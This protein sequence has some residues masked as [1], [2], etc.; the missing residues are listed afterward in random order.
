MQT[1]SPPVRDLLLVGGGHTHIQVLRSLGMQPIPGVRVTLLTREIRSPYSG[2]LPGHIAGYYS[3]DDM[4]VDL[5]PL[6]HRAGV[7]LIHGEVTGLDIEARRV[8]VHD[9]PSIAFDWLSLN[10]GALPQAPALGPGGGPARGIAVKPIGRF[11]PAWDQARALLPAGSSVAVV[12]AGA[13][14]VELAFALLAARSD[15]Q[16]SIVGRQW[17]PGFSTRAGQLLQQQAMARGIT[18]VLGVEAKDFIGDQLHLVDGAPLIAHEVFWVTDVVAPQWLKTSQLK[19]DDRGFVVVDETLRSV[20]HPHVL[21]A[22]DV[23]CLYGQERA[24]SGV[25]AVRAGP[26]LT[27]NL[28][29]IPAGT[30]LRR[31]R[32]QQHFLRLLGTSD[33][34]AV[35]A[36]WGI[37]VSGP[38]MWRWKDWIDRE[39]M[40]RFRD[41]PTRMATTASVLPEVM[42]R[43]VPDL[44]R[45]GGCGAKLG[46]DL[47]QRV[48]ARLPIT[49]RAGVLLGIGDDAAEIVADGSVL[50]S[51][52]GL[53]TMVD[54]PYRFGRIVTHHNLNDLYAMGAI[55]T[56]AVALATIP[57]MGEHLMEEEL[58]ALL[59]GVVDVLE[60]HDVPLVGGHSAE[61]AELF[62]GLTVTGRRGP[63]TFTK[64]G[65]KPG[66]QLILT[67]PIGTGVI[68]A[69]AKRGLPVADALAEAMLSM[70]TSN[71]AAVDILVGSGA[72]GVTD[73]TGFGLLGHLSEM[74]RASGVGAHVAVESV[75]I[76]GGA[77]ALLDSGVRS[78]LQA[79]NEQVLADFVVNGEL[80]ARL[81]C[82]PQTSGGLLAGVSK[83]GAQQCVDRLRA[84]GFVHAVVIGEVTTGSCELIRRF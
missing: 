36:K 31:F 9:R 38:L 48:L 34:S 57:L 26:I 51:T 24:K 58:T 47:L 74:L 10:S 60:A 55:P 7:R 6:C 67:K 35:A 41:L 13:G 30:S 75:P 54:D 59:T 52:D 28:R 82:D 12:G 2:M 1:A 62:L 4:H 42:Q 63:V 56:S 68:L 71:A 49:A 3:R 16:V 40:Q 15:L 33:G 66:Q 43:D 14:G 61:G 29:A 77:Q 25:F 79:N 65:L 64:R 83:D 39:F 76:L 53:R 37:A 45:C 20:S 22:G 5:V 32:P 72:T 73:V 70:D 84:A 18:L 81:L 8:S 50:V 44:M 80:D 23:A 46:A 19:T 17:L 69:A 11:L 27:H 21:A 78:S